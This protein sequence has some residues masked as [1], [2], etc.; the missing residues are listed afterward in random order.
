MGDTPH[1]LVASRTCE[2]ECRQQGGLHTLAQ[3]EQ[4]RDTEGQHQGTHDGCSHRIRL[5]R[6]L[7][8]DRRRLRLHG[9]R[10]WWRRHLDLLTIPATNDAAR[11]NVTGL[12]RLQVLEQVRQ[13]PGRLLLTVDV[14]KQ[15]GH[16]LRI[17]RARLVGHAGWKVGKANDGHTVGSGEAL[18][19]PCELAI[20]PTNGCKINDH[21]PGLHAGH[22]L[23]RDEKWGALA[24]DRCCGNHN[25]HLRQH[26]SERL[27]L[28]PLE[29]IGALLR[30][31][32][33]A[34]PVLLEVDGYPL[35]THGMHLIGDIAYVPRTNHRS[36]G[37][38]GADR[39]QP[40]DTTPEHEGLRGRVLARRCHLSGV[41]AAEGMRRLY[42]GPVAGDLGL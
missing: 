25:V 6:R 31:A 32:T 3:A 35:C 30:V 21:A 36:Q 23:L 17:H 20:P 18:I 11:H 8:L 9:R 28:R 7:R 37:L 14:C 16:V 19:Q 39:S 24:R 4:A 15:V 27:L 41:E 12:S 29:G 13:K 40:G 2:Q 26:L 5:C 34:R 1:G 42:D 10:L 33:C 38:R 22:S